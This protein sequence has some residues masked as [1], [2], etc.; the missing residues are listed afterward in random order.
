MGDLPRLWKDGLARPPF[1]SAVSIAPEICWRRRRIGSI[2]PHPA[3]GSIANASLAEPLN[4]PGDTSSNGPAA[5][6][7]V[8]RGRHRQETD[9]P[10]TAVLVC[11]RGPAAG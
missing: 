10:N 3:D 8:S 11:V 7:V 4:I 1:G 2:A 6:V 9:R 5:T